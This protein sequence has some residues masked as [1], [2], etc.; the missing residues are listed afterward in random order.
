MTKQGFQALLITKKVINRGAPRRMAPGSQLGSSLLDQKR[1]RGTAWRS[2]MTIHILLEILARGC[3]MSVLLQRGQVS[4]PSVVSW[5]SFSTRELTNPTPTTLRA[6]QVMLNE[7]VL[8]I[9]QRIAPKLRGY[10]IR[11]IEILLLLLSRGRFSAATSESSSF[12][13][14]PGLAQRS[15]SLRGVDR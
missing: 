9:Q 15:S 12:P 11:P 2:R 1:R 8:P 7:S 10:S 6:P 4:F 3:I 13:A 5:T 14:L